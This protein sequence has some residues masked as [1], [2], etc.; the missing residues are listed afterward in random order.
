MLYLR[1]VAL[2]VLL[3]G[4]SAVHAAPPFKTPQALVEGI[5]AEIEAS[6][7]WENFDQEAGFEPFDTFSSELRARVT[8]ADAI[9]NPT[10]EFIG[11]LDFSPFF[12]GQDST[13]MTFV[14]GAAV[15]KGGK[16]SAP[17]QILLE[18]EVLHELRVV[19]VEEAGVWKVDDFVLPGDD[20]PWRLT[21]YL[22][23]PLNF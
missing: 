19:M 17:V 8:A 11:A 18:G 12:Y 16:A 15:S 23:D 2:L 6:S 13:G 20:G 5:Y 3:I 14:I 7:Y 21:D 22:A 4:A 1:L 9:V 10:G